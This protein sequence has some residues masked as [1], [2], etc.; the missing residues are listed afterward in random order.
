MF[1]KK[2][3]IVI[4]LASIQTVAVGACVGDDAANGTPSSA[5]DASPSG[6]DAGTGIDAT[7]PKNEDSAAPDAD[8][9]RPIQCPADG[10]TSCA[11]LLARN[12]GLASGTYSIDPDGA[13]TAFSAMDAYCDNDTDGGGWTLVLNYVHKDGTNPN[14]VERTTLPVVAGSK[15]GDDESASASAWGHA[16]LALVSALAP[17]DLRFYGAT[18]AHARIVN[19]KT[20]GA[21]CIAYAKTGAGSCMGIETSFTPLAGHTAQLP[22]Q[23]DAW[24]SDKGALALTTFPFYKTSTVHWSIKGG[25]AR[26]EVDGYSSNSVPS[27]AFD[28]IHRVFVR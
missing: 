18:S 9:A 26:W 22:A 4:F 6:V 8:A 1:E 24:M 2:A 3:T 19:F 12:A 27:G 25:G 21:A 5:G 16:S 13:G 17:K 28:T 23:A 10:C 11:D 14:V 15:L 7:P 20:S